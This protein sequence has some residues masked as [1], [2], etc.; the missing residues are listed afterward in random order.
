M[1]Q[2]DRLQVYVVR[3]L[4]WEYGDCFSCRTEARDAPRGTFLDRGKGEARRRRLE[5]QYICDRQVNPFGWIDAGLEGRTSL[6]PEEF[7]P[8]LRQAGLRLGGEDGWRS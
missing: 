1:A 7:F 3:R 2:R 8:R 6:P 4:G 5:W